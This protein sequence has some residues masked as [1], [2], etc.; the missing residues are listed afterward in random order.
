MSKDAEDR[1]ARFL[2]VDSQCLE[3]LNL[4]IACAHVIHVA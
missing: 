1:F 4:P 3:M 2:E